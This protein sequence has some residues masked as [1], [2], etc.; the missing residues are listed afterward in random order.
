MEDFITFVKDPGASMMA[1]VD[2]RQGSGQGAAP[3]IPGLPPG[4]KIGVELDPAKLG[5]IAVAG[6]RRTYRL[7]AWGEVK[8]KVIDDK[9]EPIWSIR[10]GITGVWDT[11]VVN[12]SAR[13]P[14]TRNGAWVF[15]RE[16]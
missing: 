7:V 9:G 4:T 14:E 16:E 12:Q 15:L 8:S 11:K 3:Q 1:M 6:P 10:R 5:Q 13:N 2:E